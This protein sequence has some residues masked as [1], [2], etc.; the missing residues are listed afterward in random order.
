MEIL[1]GEG[2]LA[3]EPVLRIRDLRVGTADGDIVR[4]VD[5][6]IARGQVVGLVGESGCGTTTLALSIAGLLGTSRRVLGGSIA[7]EGETIVDTGT[8]RTQPL[9]GGRVGF[10]PQDPFGALDPLRHVGPQL[11]RP[12]R[13]HRRMSEEGALDRIS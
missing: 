5:L 9:R 1:L 11:A 2:E 6:E 12:L 7:F 10:V 3:G 8:D 4:G 13:L